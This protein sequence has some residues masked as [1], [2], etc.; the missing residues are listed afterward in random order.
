MSKELMSEIKTFIDNNKNDLLYNAL[1]NEVAYYYDYIKSDYTDF[2]N[3]DFS[4]EDFKNITDDI[5]GS[6]YMNEGLNE[7]IQ[8]KLYDYVKGV[9]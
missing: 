7:M 8:G 6:Y 4:L 1:L 9:K 5:I 2:D 3:T